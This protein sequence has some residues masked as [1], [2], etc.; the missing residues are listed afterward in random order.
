MERIVV[1]DTTTAPL[2][3]AEVLPVAGGF[4]PSVSDEG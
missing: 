1:G 4:R 2:E 3:L